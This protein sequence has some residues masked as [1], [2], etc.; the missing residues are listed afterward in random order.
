MVVNQLGRHVGLVD[1]LFY[2]CVFS[3]GL[4]GIHLGLTTICKL[5]TFRVGKFPKMVD[6][7]NTMI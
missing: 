6:N 7:L 3:C 4:C 1:S 2:H 5:A